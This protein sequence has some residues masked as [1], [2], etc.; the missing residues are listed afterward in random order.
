M[1]HRPAVELYNHTV[2]D[3]DLSSAESYLHAEVRGRDL[4]GMALTGFQTDYRLS[5]ILIGSER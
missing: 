5:G 2:L 1:S 3:L 4:I